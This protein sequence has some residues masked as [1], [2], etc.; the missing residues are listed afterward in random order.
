LKSGGVIS[1]KP[2]KTDSSGTY[3]FTVKVVDKKT[4]TKPHTQNVTTERLSI[5]VS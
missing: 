1:G 2:K 5:T 4:K 3:S